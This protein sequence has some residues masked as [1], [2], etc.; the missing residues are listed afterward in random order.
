MEDAGQA[1]VGTRRTRHVRRPAVPAPRRAAIGPL[2][3]SCPQTLERRPPD[4]RAQR[5]RHPGEYGRSTRGQPRSTGTEKGP[6]HTGTP[7]VISPWCANSKPRLGS[8][9]KA[10]TGLIQSSQ[11]GYRRSPDPHR[12]VPPA[13]GGPMIS[14]EGTVVALGTLIGK[15]KIGHIRLCEASPRASRQGH[16]RCTGSPRRSRSTLSPPVFRKPPSCGSPASWHQASCHTRQGRRVLT[17]TMYTSSR[18][19]LEA[20]AHVLGSYLLAAIIVLAARAM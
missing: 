19:R 5:P 15:D 8:S 2:V 10:W 11:P 14:I 1:R 7:N 4:D 18:R 16:T 20:G 12:P 17:S 13:P 9:W 3:G 6:W